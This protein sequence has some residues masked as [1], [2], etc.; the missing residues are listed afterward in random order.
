MHKQ[1][2]VIGGGVGGLTA[3]ALLAKLDYEVTV[4]EASREWGGCAGK[5][6]RHL[7]TFPVGATLGM[8]FEHGGIHER[9]GMYLGLEIEKVS[10]EKIM[11]VHLPHRTLIYYQDR[12][13]H[14]SYLQKQFPHKAKNIRSF[15][16]NVFR[17]AK[18]I[19]KLMQSLLVLPPL[20]VGEWSRLVSSLN[21]GSVKLLPYFHQSFSYLL[22][23]HSLLDEADFLHFVDGQLIDSMQTTSENCSML[24]GC[25][26]LDI[27]HEGAFYVNGGL[28]KVA[29]ALQKSI[30]ANGGKTTLGRKVVKIERDND[31]WIVHDHRGNRYRA[32][33]VVC[34]APVQSLKSLLHDE[35][36][37]H[38]HKRAKEKSELPQWGTFSMYFAIDERDLPQKVELFQQVLQSEQGEM[39]EGNHL[40]IS[41]SHP[42]D[43]FRAPEGK[44]TI[45]ASTHIDLSKWSNKEAYDL[46]KQVLEK[47]MVAGIKTI[48]PS[49]EKAEH[50]ISGAPKAWERFTSRPNGGVGGFPQTLD[51]ALFNSISHRSGLQ[52]LWLCGDT[53]FP[54]AGTIGV[55]VSGYHVFQSI[56]SHRHTL[57]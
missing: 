39:T 44:R 38:I 11:K 9:I 22:K 29:E 46:Q 40:F 32:S 50:Q 1:V 13:Q 16:E 8:G 23:K 47:K 27:Y 3:G 21:F 17:I 49:I 56:T 42:D 28:Y 5:F 20:T 34:N 37:Q 55:S 57:P 52:G 6:Q 19:R 7:Y 18:E 54:G 45:T 33:D 51:H 12:Y 30:K 36:Y 15:Y 26:A 14:I 4:L 31:G 24:I 35:D 41:V 48:I 53:V 43:R 10:L 2:V 25:L